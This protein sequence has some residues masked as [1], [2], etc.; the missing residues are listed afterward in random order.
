MKAILVLL[1][2][3]DAVN[4]GPTVATSSSS[5]QIPSQVQ[6]ANENHTT[7]RVESKRHPKS[8]KFKL[9]RKEASG[10][11]Y[12]TPTTPHSQTIRSSASRITPQSDQIPVIASHVEDGITKAGPESSSISED[13]LHP[14][15]PRVPRKSPVSDTV[16]ERMPV[17]A[18]LHGQ[19]IAMSNASSRAQGRASSTADSAPQL[20]MIVNSPS[21]PP[22]FPSNPSS[23]IASAL[24]PDAFVI[25]SPSFP[26]PPDRSGVRSTSR[27][28]LMLDEVR[29]STGTR[30]ARE[31][32][33]NSKEKK[34]SRFSADR[35]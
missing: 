2:Q 18:P 8:S 19:R 9:A 29:E 16:M 6:P 11:T 15:V 20:S 14:G 28:V 13:M 23:S 25:S 26:P 27:S 7:S 31:L 4:V 33:G 3:G 34:I 5:D 17:Q 35:M 1:Q 30:G 32:S 22:P 21:F 24:N 10:S 12:L